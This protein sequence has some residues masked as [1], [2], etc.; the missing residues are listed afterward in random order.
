M[1]FKSPYLGLTATSGHPWDIHPDG[2]RFLMMKPQDAASKEK[3]PRPKMVVVTNWF[4]EL[5]QRAPAK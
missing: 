3:G 5:K 2:K 4:E 1:L